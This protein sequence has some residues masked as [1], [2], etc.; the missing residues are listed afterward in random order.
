MVANNL[1]GFLYLMFHVVLGRR[2]DAVDYASMVA[3]LGLLNLLNI[4]AAAIQISLARFVAEF[5][6][7]NAVQLWVTIV[8]RAIFRITV[9]GLLGLALWCAVSMPLQV[10]LKAPSVPSI[11]IIGMIAFISLYAP[12]VQG[13]L[14]GAGRFAWMACGSVVLAAARLVFAVIVLLWLGGGISP[15]LFTIVLSTIM[16]LVVSYWPIRRI[17]ATTPSIPGY[18][19]LPIYRYLWFVLVGQGALFLLM[20]M[21]LVLST[22]FL[23]GDELAAYGKS[24]MLARTVLFLPQPIAMAMFPRAVTS[25]N[26]FLILGPLVFS[27]L[28]SLAGATFIT[29][30]PA[31]PMY[32]MYGVDAPLYLHVCRMYVWAA[33]PLSLILVLAQYLWARGAIRKILGITPM[34]L[35]YIAAL[36]LYHDTAGQMILC[37]G[38]S[39]SLVVLWLVYLVFGLKSDEQKSS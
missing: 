10:E 35:F 25:S 37:L 22:R 33:V 36:F 17:V 16:G 23:E 4:P 8:R 21:D 29:L 18:D 1:A 34:V 14:Q 38:I 6:H 2:M 27:L 11:I 32:L 12:I 24:A 7:Q 31:I 28:V 30:Y 19:T 5:T 39:S 13:V 3:L 20:N 9:W 26:R 15:M